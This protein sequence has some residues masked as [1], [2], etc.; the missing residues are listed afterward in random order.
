MQILLLLLLRE[1]SSLLWELSSVSMGYR[2]LVLWIKEDS[3]IISLNPSNHSFECGH[4]P[5]V[6]ISL[7]HGA[8]I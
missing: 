5:P 1:L 3:L 6:F 8:K 2:C 4:E 7:M